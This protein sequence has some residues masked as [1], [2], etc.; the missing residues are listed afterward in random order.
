VGNHRKPQLFLAPGMSVEVEITNV[1]T[2]SNSVE[3]ET[4]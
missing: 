1:G 3:D 2:L 4:A